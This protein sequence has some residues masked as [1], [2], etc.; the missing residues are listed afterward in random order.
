MLVSFPNVGSSAHGISNSSQ[1][2]NSTDNPKSMR[3]GKELNCF[4][5]LEMKVV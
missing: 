5:P 1:N 2:F 3:N 4:K